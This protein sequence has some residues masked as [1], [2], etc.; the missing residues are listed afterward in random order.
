MTSFPN[1]MALPLSRPISDHIPCVIKIGTLIPRGKKITFENYWIEHS[2]F[3]HIV[4]NAWNIPLGFTDSAKCI[5]A[6]LKNLRRALKNWAKD[7]S[8]LK[9]E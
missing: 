5:N 4:A 6:K 9:R 1:T 8:C 3:K 2:D 7:L